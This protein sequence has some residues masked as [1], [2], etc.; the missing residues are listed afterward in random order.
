VQKAFALLEELQDGHAHSGEEIATK[1]GV[2]RTAV[3]NHVKR[4]QAEGVEIHAVSGKGYR[5]PG[6][7]EFLNRHAIQLALGDVGQSAINEL[8]VDL[9][10]DSTN[11]RLLD[12][13][14][15]SDIHGIAWLA[16]YQSRGRGRRGGSWLAPPGSGLCLSLGWRF[17]APPSSMSALS[18]V[19]G[20]AVVRALNQL[21]ASKLNLKWPNDIYHRERKLAGILIEMRSEFG[22]PCTVAIGIGVNIALSPDAHARINEI[23]TDVSSACGFVPS[24][25]KAAAGILNELT[26]VLQ[27][28]AHSGFDPYRSEWQRHDHLADRRIRLEMPERVV[29]GVARGV[30]ADGTLL[31]E[32]D[33]T[34]E[35]FLAGHIVMDAD[36]DTPD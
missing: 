9:V 33:G 28:F 15:G 34:T 5:L 36:S 3:W 19:V 30:A 17:D 16:E 2:T 11:Q 14:S 31:I 20:I 25:N 6:G 13:I 1:L 18:L 23:A 22:G 26:L 27:D 21:G 8:H 32:H 10:V 24:R 12:L 35:A 7:Y 29:H 4:L